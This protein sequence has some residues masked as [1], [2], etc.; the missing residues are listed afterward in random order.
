MMA[1]TRAYDLPAPP[2]SRA[3]SRTLDR[4]DTDQ[5]ELR[6]VCFHVGDEEYGLD[7]M[8][9]REVVAPLALTRVAD[10]PAFFAGI[11]ALR[12]RFIGVLDL[13]MILYPDQ[14]VEDGRG[15][16]QK[17]VL[18]H[19]DGR[20]FGLLV[21]RVT[22]VLAVERA[23]MTSLADAVPG[24]GTGGRYLTAAVRIDERVVLVIDP[25]RLLAPAQRQALA[26][27]D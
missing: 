2:P 11:A 21:D 5:P 15:A 12:G 19:L 4:A 10:A 18:T 26:N 9:V 1:M 25:E 6:L 7:I 22:E 17:Y 27:M 20:V 3:P 8:Q 23:A 16:D 13:R 24:R 14:P